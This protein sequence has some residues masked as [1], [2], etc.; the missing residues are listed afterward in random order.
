MGASE[1]EGNGGPE[2]GKIMGEN[3]R[4]GAVLGNWDRLERGEAFPEREVSGAGR[5]MPVLFCGVVFLMRPGKSS[6]SV[7]GWHQPFQPPSSFTAIFSSLHENL[8][9][10][11]NLVPDSLG[12]KAEGRRLQS[13]FLSAGRS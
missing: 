4:V 6:P 1:A 11:P 3:G 10:H 7:L 8:Q 13:S 12:W 2:M 5:E 9:Q